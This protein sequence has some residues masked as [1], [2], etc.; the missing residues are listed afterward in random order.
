[1][2]RTTISWPDDLAEA[3][4][5][6]ARRRHVS[7]S[8]VVREAVEAHLAGGRAGG[9]LIP[10]AG[11]GRSDGPPHAADLDEYL[12]EHWAADVASDR[13]QGVKA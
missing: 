6:E 4:Q 8:E 13:G 2:K 12:A 3:V 9:R 7:V 5:R 10:W 1:M 11:I